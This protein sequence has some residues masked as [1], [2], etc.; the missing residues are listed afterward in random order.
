MNH[1][2]GSG[3]QVQTEKGHISLNESYEEMYLA[4]ILIYVKTFS[5]HL[6][7]V[8]SYL[9]DWLYIQFSILKIDCLVKNLKCLMGYCDKGHSRIHDS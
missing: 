1:F 3:L 4:L 8:W 2:G 9:I 7:Q 5:D 6:S